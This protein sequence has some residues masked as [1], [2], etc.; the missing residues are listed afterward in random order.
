MENILVTENL[1]VNYGRRIV[2]NNLNMTIPKGAVYG[3]VG[4]NGAGKSTLIRTVCGMIRPSGGSYSLFGVNFN[5][6]AISEVRRRMGAV[7]EAPGLYPELTAYENLKIQYKLLGLPSEDGIGELLELMKLT[8]IGTQKVKNYSLG[9]KQRLGIALALACRPDFILLDEPANGL[10]PQ[11]IVD[12]RE[13]L[14]ELNS[15]MNLTILISS[16]ILE[17]L[18]RV[19]TCYGFLKNGKIVQEISAKELNSRCRDC[20]RVRVSDTKLLARA[21]DRLGAEYVI[22]SDTEALLYTDLFISDLTA[23]LG[24][25][26]C[27]LERVD[28]RKETLETFY[29]NVIGGDDSE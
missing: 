13:L 4:K 7:A 11:G 29:L 28:D 22:L 23:A 9:M 12:L 25:E 17:E 1:R 16:H 14:I 2:L 3:L 18:P 15:R 6:R 20:L 8:D 24:A 5:S 21:M 27:V 10:D 19:A 26:G